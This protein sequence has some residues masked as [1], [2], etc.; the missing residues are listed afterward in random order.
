LKK[1]ASYFDSAFTSLPVTFTPE[2]EDFA[3]D[4]ELFKG[5]SYTSLEFGKVYSFVLEIHIIGSLFVRRHQIGL[6]S[7]YRFVHHHR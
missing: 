6:I 1:N 3:I 5:F 7:Q 4:Q 2:P